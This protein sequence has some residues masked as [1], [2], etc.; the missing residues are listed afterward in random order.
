[1]LVEQRVRRA[2]D[3]DRRRDEGR[4]EDQGRDAEVRQERRRQEDRDRDQRAKRP[5]GPR[6]VAGT[7]AGREQEDEPSPIDGGF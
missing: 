1:V 2:G 3:R 7:E 4:E 5:G 6:G